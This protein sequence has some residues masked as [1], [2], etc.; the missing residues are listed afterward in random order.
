MHLEKLIFAKAIRKF[1]GY[2]LLKEW[3]K[4][5]VRDDLSQ[6]LMGLDSQAGS[7]RPPNPVGR[8]TGSRMNVT[9]GGEPVSARFR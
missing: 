6:R 1:R 5:A 7:K 9:R 3:P 2:F 8:Q 4:I